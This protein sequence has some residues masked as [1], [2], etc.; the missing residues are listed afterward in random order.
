[1]SFSSLLRIGIKPD[2]IRKSWVMPEVKTILERGRGH[3]VQLDN[4]DPLKDL[5]FKFIIPSKGDL[6]AQSL[7]TNPKFE[8][9]EAASIYLCGNSLGVQPRCTADRIASHLSAWAKKGVY[10]HFTEHEDSNLPGFL[11]IDDTA[12]K[13]MAPVV[14]ALPGEVAVM[15]TLTANLHLMM[16]SF[17]RPTKEKYKVILEGKAFPSD[18]YAVESQIKQHG[19]DVK[20][21]M[22]LIEPADPHSPTIS[23]SHIL[24]VIDKHASTTAL[25]LLPGIQYYT[26]QYLDIKQITARAHSHST[27]IGWDL[28]HA[29]GNVELLLHDWDVDFAVWCNYKYLNSG[30]GAVGGLFVH[31]KHGETDLAAAQEEKEAY[32]P[33]LAGWWGGDKSIRFEMGSRRS[34]TVSPLN[35]QRHLRPRRIRAHTRRPRVSGWQSVCSCSLCGDCLTRGFRTYFHVRASKEVHGF[36]PVS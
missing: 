27:L 18:H 22:V 31:S 6:K 20:E 16:A 23:T 3:A 25:I 11:H 34:Y 15:E 28:A 21:A 13:L 14:G 7:A 1:L 24:S 35:L 17:Y 5:R 12:A 9:S 30:P 2:F 36:D 4:D 8:D 26:G 19:L 32:R 29:V 10:G 33:R